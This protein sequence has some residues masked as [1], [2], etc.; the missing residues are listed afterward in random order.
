MSRHF[1]RSIAI[2][3]F[4]GINN[5]GDPLVLKFK[6][7][8]V[9]SVHAQNGGGKTSIF[10]A[11]QFAIRGEIPRLTTLQEA[12]QG[13]SYIVNKFH[14]AKLA[15]IELTF[16]PDSGGADVVVVVKRTG[17]GVRTVSSPSGHPDPDSFLRSLDEDFVLVDYHTF[18]SFIDA[19]A[20]NR[21]RS[22]AALIGLSSYSNLRQALEGA[23]NTRTINTDLGITL[24][25]QRVTAERGKVN[26]SKRRVIEGYQELTAKEIIQLDD[27]SALEATVTTV[28][29]GIGT[30][31]A[32]MAGKTVADFDYK[33]AVTAIEADEDSINRRK[34]A[35]MRDDRDAI[36]ALSFSADHTM[37]L[38]ALL[39]AA[40]DRDDAVQKVGSAEIRELLKKAATIVGTPAWPSDQSCPVCELPQPGP[41]KA[42]LEEKIALYDAAQELDAALCKL[43]SECPAIELLAKLETAVPLAIPGTA[44]I[45]PALTSAAKKGLVPTTDLL[46]LHKRIEELVAARDAKVTDLETE[47]KTL[48]DT[49]P[50]SVVAASRAVENAKKFRDEYDNYAKAVAVVANDL[51]KLGK[52]QRWRSFI[53]KASEVFSKAETTLSTARLVDIEGSYKSLFPLLMRGAPD[54]KP[55]L[56]RAA[57]SENIDLRLSDFHGEANISARA[58]LSESYRNAVAASIFLSAAT[59]NTRPPRFMVLDDITSSFDGGHQ[60]FLM[61]A[62]L[63]KLRNGVAAGGIQFI[64][65]SHDSALEKYFDKLGNTPEWHHQKLQ[66]LPPKGSILSSAQDS[67]RL[68]KQ[69]MDLLNVGNVELGGLLVRQ[70]MEYK[71]GYTISK[72]QVPVPP[73]Y[74]TRPD[75]RTLSTY[76]D[77][78]TNA[79][80][81]FHKAGTCVLDAAQIAAVGNTAV[82]SLMSNMVS[83]YETG[84][85]QP[86]NAYA[87]LGVIGEIDA[88]AENFRRAD[89]ANPSQRAY[90]K[91]LNKT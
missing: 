90:Y 56:S 51:V 85:G 19:T 49:L 78:I 65:L 12:E 48:E 60:F 18:A 4:R 54:L 80:D 37:Q 3:G 69:A 68:K 5:S 6:P 79:V 72:L 70:Y 61:D 75:K 25:E 88:Y 26:D 31:K 47:I 84:T 45:A 13:D 74:A 34:L 9:N 33:A 50:P 36:R 55:Q 20:L 2:E 46:V 59:K 8:C 40:N 41:L 15:T 91:A 11:L 67:N 86:L 22:F 39:M 77:A 71:L 83:H 7:E 66:G 23:D 82:S 17:A 27:R 32:V 28:L 64:I 43:C 53:H 44:Q 24:L 1:L 16:A 42:K 76:L 87:M 21:G 10:E 73:D 63:L 58:V 35:K 57:N 38:D 81:L 89:P 52:L 62:L 14:P 30:L 29:A